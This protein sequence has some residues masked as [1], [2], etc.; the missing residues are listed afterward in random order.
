MDQAERYGYF[1][2]VFRAVVENNMAGLASIDNLKILH[3]EL[4]CY[5]FQIARDNSNPVIHHNK[6][7][8]SF[9]FQRVTNFNVD[10]N[11][12]PADP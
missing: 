4:A 6:T 8:A 5:W 10:F 2:E 9:A 1:A 11:Y 12:S 3:R 7:P